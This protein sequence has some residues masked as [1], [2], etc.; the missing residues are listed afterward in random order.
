VGVVVVGVVVLYGPGEAVWHWGLQE[1][2]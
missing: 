1:F 2:T